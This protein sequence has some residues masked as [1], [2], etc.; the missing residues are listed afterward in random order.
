M[1][2]S[3]NTEYCGIISVLCTE[4]SGIRFLVLNI[5]VLDLFGNGW[6]VE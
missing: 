2:P 1:G 6:L 5:V 4:D 3:T